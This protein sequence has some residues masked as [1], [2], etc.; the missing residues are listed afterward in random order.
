[1]ARFG[2]ALGGDK[3]IGVDEDAQGRGV[4]HACLPLACSP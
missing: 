2:V 3:D 4:S 1:V